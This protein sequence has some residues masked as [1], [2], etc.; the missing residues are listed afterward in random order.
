M[1]KIIFGLLTGI[2]IFSSCKKKFDLPP[3]AVMPAVSSYITID[4]IINRY[5]VYYVPPA[6]APTKFY[7]FSGDV[8]LECVVTADETSGN[9]YKTVFINF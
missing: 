4:S 1:N 8:N 2:I 3:T 5:G 7:R 6:P 9:I